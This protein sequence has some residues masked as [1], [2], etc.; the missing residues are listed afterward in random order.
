MKRKNV[1]I[2][3]CA[4]G[5]IK[6]PHHAIARSR[7]HQFPSKCIQIRSIGFSKLPIGIKRE[8]KWLFM[9]ML[10]LWPAQGEPCPKTVWIGCSFYV[11]P[12]LQEELKMD[13]LKVSSTCPLREFVLV[14]LMQQACSFGIFI[15]FKIE[16]DFICLQ[17]V[18]LLVTMYN[19][20][21]AVEI[22]FFKHWC[23][24]TGGCLYA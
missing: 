8:C 1:C 21:S 5:H 13:P 16:K 3:L 19:V 11:T 12:I 24:L 20:K 23:D 6:H 18:K 15:I 7:L 10:D 22:Y 4:T 14:P 2:G 17:Y 9:S